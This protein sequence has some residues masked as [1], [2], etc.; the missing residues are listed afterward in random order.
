MPVSSVDKI[1]LPERPAALRYCTQIAFPYKLVVSTYELK[2]GLRRGSL[3]FVDDS[4]SKIKN[5]QMSAGVFRFDLF[6]DG[7]TLVAS[8]TN[9]CLSTVN[10]ESFSATDLLVSMDAMLLSAC[11]SQQQVLCSDNFG[12][13]HVVDLLSGSPLFRTVFF[14]S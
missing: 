10:L 1:I 4:H 13:V 3:W 5:L 9:G 6:P 2:G 14:S 12:N 11:V 7:I 8:L